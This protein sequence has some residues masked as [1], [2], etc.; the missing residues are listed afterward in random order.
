MPGQ[1]DRKET[2]W[3]ELAMRAEL[4]RAQLQEAF[5]VSRI[6]KVSFDQALQSPCLTL[7][8][9][10]TA[11]ALKQARAKPAPKPRIDVKRIAAGDID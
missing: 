5:K 3:L 10:N 1:S 8:L 6:R 7:A 11:L 9:I 2:N 4:T